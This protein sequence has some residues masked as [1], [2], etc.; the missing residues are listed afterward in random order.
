MTTKSEGTPGQPMTAHTMSMK[1]E[2]RRTGECT[3]KETS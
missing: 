3:G 2:A 1:M